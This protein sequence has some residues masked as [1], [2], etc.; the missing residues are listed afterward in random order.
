MTGY[1]K[2]NRNRWDQVIKKVHTLSRMAGVT[3]VMMT[4]KGE[5]LLNYFG[6][7]RAI[8]MFSEFP[9]ELQTNGIWLNENSPAL[10]ELAKVGLDVVAVSIDRMSDF[11]RFAKLYEATKANNRMLR[12]CINV[13]SNRYLTNDIKVILDEAIRVKADQLLFRRVTIPKILTNT[14][15]AEKTRG[16]IV[17]NVDF[18][19][20]EMLHNEFKRLISEQNDLVRRMPHGA[21]VYDYKNKISVSFSDYCV[22]ECNN[23]DDIRSLILLTDGHVYTSWDKKSSILL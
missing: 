23:T 13:V 14:S 3:N 20:Y 19:M 8:Q 5:P 18:E 16:W 22:Q 4:G 17:N 21:L 1:D 7:V 11:E 12:I 9:V 10:K 2:Y 15:E 6:L